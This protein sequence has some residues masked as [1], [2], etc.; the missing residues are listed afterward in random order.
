V[1]VQQRYGGM[2]T[3]KQVLKERQL[4]EVDEYNGQQRPEGGEIYAEQGG[5]LPRVRF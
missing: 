5:D 2:P 1:R 3:F 4:D